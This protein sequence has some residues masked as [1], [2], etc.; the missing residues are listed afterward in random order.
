MDLGLTDKIAIVTGSSRGLGLASARALVAEGLPRVPLR[1]RRGAAGRGGGRS[2]SRGA[3]GRTWSRPCRLTCRPTTASSSS[4]SRPSRRSAGSTSSSTTSAAPAARDLLDTSDA[5]WQAAF[6]ETLFP[7]I[8]AS[9]LAVPHMRQRGGG[10]IVMI[11]SICGPRV[12]RPHDLQRR[13]GR[14]D[15]PRQVARAAARAAQHPRQQRRARLDPVP[16]RI[17][18]QAPAGRSRRASPTSSSAS[19]RSAASAAPTK[20][21]PS[22]RS[23]PRR[24]RAGSAARASRWMAVSGDRTSERCQLSLELSQATIPT[25]PIVMSPSRQLAAEQSRSHLIQSAADGLFMPWVV[26]RA[27]RGRPVPDGPHRRSCRSAGSARPAGWRSSGARAAP[28]AR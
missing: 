13:Q 24:A 28:T 8:R 27:V 21:A 15:Q 26:A 22:S 19:C 10:A 23:S 11:A 2:R 9:R 4:S 3:S 7:A 5:E 12:G 20:S 25:D 18:A 14:R 16:R 1:A 6:D 17:L